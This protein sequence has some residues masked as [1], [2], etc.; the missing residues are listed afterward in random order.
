[1]MDQL[2]GM[3]FTSIW[4]ALLYLLILCVAATVLDRIVDRLVGKVVSG[5]SA[6]V[7]RLV[8]MGALCAGVLWGAD[9]LMS[10]VWLNGWTLG[11]LAVLAAV[12]MVLPENGQ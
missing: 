2:L 8:V 1:M 6:K 4:W 3:H 11:G 10:G 5:A 7:T 12:L 9:A